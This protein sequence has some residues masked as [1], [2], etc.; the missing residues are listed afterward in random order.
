MSKLGKSAGAGSGISA[1]VSKQFAQIT[2]YTSVMGDEMSGTKEK[3]NVLQS[4]I[5][6]LTNDGSKGS[7]ALANN[8]KTA[9]GSM[10]KSLS[11]LSGKQPIFTQLT[12]GLKAM[13]G[14]AAQAG[15]MLETISSGAAG[16]AGTLS[17]VGVALTILKAGF[18]AVILPGIKFNMMLEQQ[19]V[20]FEVMLK[21]ASAAT[22]LVT[23]LKKLTMS[24]GVSLA[25]SMASVKQMLAYGFGGEE[26]IS[27]LKML[28]TVAK[29]VNVP[30]TDLTYVYGTLRAQGRAYTRD[31]MQFAMRG[32]PIYEYLAKVLE[33]D[34]SKLKGLIEEGKVGFPEVEKAFQMMTGEGGKFSGM[35]EKWTQYRYS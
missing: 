21:S 5:R 8:Y 35:L 25:D 6:G 3:I 13:G 23:D 7:M 4:A 15:T 19:T 12:D 16:L 34:V 17:I 31:I 28:N 26:M 24:T 22:E 11:S 30:M 33:V 32:I 9:L 18:D 20:A 10:Q 14:P 29:A 27:S 1:N 2:R